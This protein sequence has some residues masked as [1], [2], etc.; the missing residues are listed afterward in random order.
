MHKTCPVFK[1]LTKKKLNAPRPPNLGVRG[2]YKA[3]SEYSLLEDYKESQSLKGSE[4]WLEPG[5]R[6]RNIV[7]EGER[8]VRKL[9]LELP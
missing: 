3:L 4:E 1:P 6:P 2:G 5:S 9:L 7:S 8:S